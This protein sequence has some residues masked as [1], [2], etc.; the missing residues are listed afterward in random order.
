[1][2]SVLEALT[3]VR[4]AAVSDKQ[5]IKCNVNRYL[6]SFTTIWHIYTTRL[7]FSK[8]NVRGS[9]NQVNKTCEEAGTKV[10]DAAVT[11]KPLIKCAV[12]RYL[13]S[14]TTICHI[15]TTRLEF[16][17]PNVRGS[18]NQDWRSV[19]KTCEEAGT[20]VRDAAVSDKLLITCAVNRYLSSFTTIWHIYTTRLAFSKQNV[21]GSRNQD[22]RS[23][24]KTCEEA[25]TKVR[26]AAVTDKPLIKCAVDRYLSS[27]TTI[28]HIYT[29]R[30]A[31]SK[32]TCEEA[33]TKVR[34]AAVT[35]KQL[36]KCAVG[37]YLKFFF[38]TFMPPDWR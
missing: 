15:Y 9:R 22:W 5:L 31:L 12:D 21:R 29:T 11:D 28:C 18:R 37:R 2:Q 16:S 20:K 23:V 34:D 25:G 8:Q 19:N 17:K 27:F 38:A 26:D 36:I 33:G 6:T 1:K 30:L 7:A 14:F 4:D 35:D 13:S 3:K 10:R 24:N 32:Q